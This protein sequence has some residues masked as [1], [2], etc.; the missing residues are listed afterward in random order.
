M[1]QKNIKEYSELQIKDW[2]DTKVGLGIFKH[3]NSTKQRYSKKKMKESFENP[4]LVRDTK[5]PY[6][7]VGNEIYNMILCPSGHFTKGSNNNRYHNPLEEMKIEKPFLLGET[8]ITQ[9]IYESVMRENPSNFTNQ[10]K[11]P[12]EQVSWYDALIFCNKLSNIFGL[13][14]YYTIGD[15][16]K[17]TDRKGKTTTHYPI[18]MNENSKGFR[19]PTEWEWE[20]AAKAGT[21]LEYS[22][23]ADPKEV[24]WHNFNSNNTTHPIKQ[25]KP[26]AWGFYDMTGNVWELCEN[27]YNFSSLDQCAIR[28]GCWNNELWHLPSAYRS[29]YSLSSCSSAVGFRVCK[30]I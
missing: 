3:Y 23:A 2:W 29:N 15:A 18:E 16:Q 11:N 30:Y 26:N 12:I 22:G 8:E 28:G 24:A 10:P 25:L 5:T 9:E 19:L 4:N 20:Y 1:I 14:H 13:E 17:I 27:K 6:Y 21:D 7:K